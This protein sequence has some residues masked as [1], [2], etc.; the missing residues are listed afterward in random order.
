MIFRK[1]LLREFATSAL[2]AFL[3]LLTITMATQLVR[4]LGQAASGSVTSTG[5]VALLGFNALWY[6][7]VLLSLTLF[8]AVLMTLTR[9]YR[10]SEMIV[11]FSSGLSLT[12]WI[13]PVLTFAAPLVLTIALLSLGL[14]PWAI[15]KSEEFRR[16]MD[17]RDDVAAVSPGVFRESKQAER[18]YFVENVSNEENVVANVFV[19]A[20]QHQKT[21]VMVARRGFQETA[22]NGDRFLVLLNGRRYEG[23]AGTAEYKITEF[24]RYA[25]RVETYEAKLEQPS[26]K[27]MSTVDLLRNPV[28]VNL[29]ELTWRVGLPVSALILALLAI[30][31]SFVNPRAGRSMNLV[32]ALLVYMVYSNFLSIAQ[33]WVA[34]SRISLATGLWGVHAGMLL[35]LAVLYYRRLAVISLFRLFR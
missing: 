4:F 30:P 27:A 2:G 16:Q 7:P 21:G 33:A 3:V 15:T 22:P 32:L 19:S 9:G 12:A 10:D 26:T 5:V 20:T 25:M 17:S 6:L 29:A 11:W 13:R 14:S 28:P 34:Q 31:L 23:T 1:A 8:I 35:L 18:V 24:E